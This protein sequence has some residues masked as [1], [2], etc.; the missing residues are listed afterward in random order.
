[1]LVIVLVIIT[2]K[3]KRFNRQFVDVTNNI[4]HKTENNV[5]ERKSDSDIENHYYETID[6]EGHYLEPVCNLEI[7]SPK[8]C[9]K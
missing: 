1:M 2:K 9:D 4:I 7:D 3:K 8:P 6:D 5:N